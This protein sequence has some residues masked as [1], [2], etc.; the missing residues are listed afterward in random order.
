MDAKAQIAIVEKWSKEH[1][2]N[3]QKDASIDAKG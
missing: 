3:M 1:P 2:S